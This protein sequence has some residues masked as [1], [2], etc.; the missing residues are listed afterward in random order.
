MR[1]ECGAVAPC[2]RIHHILG[3]RAADPLQKLPW[4]RKAKPSDRLGLLPCCRGLA[5]SLRDF[6]RKIGSAGGRETRTHFCFWEDQNQKYSLE[7]K[8]EGLSA[9]RR[10][11]LAGGSA[12]PKI[13]ASVSSSRPPILPVKNLARSGRPGSATEASAI[14]AA[15]WQ[16][17][18]CGILRRRAV[19]PHVA[20]LG[21]RR[22]RL[23]SAL[24]A[25]RVCRR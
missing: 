11:R 13:L 25:A 7:R 23:A 1:L 2:L 19:A 17:K 15:A 8:P 6:H 14:Q 9:Q 21:P 12:Y 4:R 3:C 18:M 22:R 16:P 20:R 10:C 24:Q 5:E